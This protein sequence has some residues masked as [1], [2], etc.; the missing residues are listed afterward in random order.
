MGKDRKTLITR[1]GLQLLKWQELRF[2]GPVIWDREV[3]GSNPLAPTIGIS[4]LR[5]PS[6]AAVSHLWTKLIGR[7]SR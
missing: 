4:I 6:L 3:G 7:M 1:G 5:L 2:A